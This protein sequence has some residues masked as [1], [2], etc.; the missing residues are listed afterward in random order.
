MAADPMYRKI[1]EDLQ[2]KIETGA[3][4]HGEQL[5]TEMEL[6]DQYDASRNTVR[7]AVKLLITRRLIETRPGQGTFV[8]EKIDPFVT[9]LTDDPESGLGG[10]EGIVYI[11]AVAASGR[12]ADASEPQVEIQRARDE[13]AESL[14]IAVGAQVVCRHQRRRIDDVPWSL[15][16]SFYPMAL[17]QR[18]ATRLLEAT[19]ITEGTVIYLRETLGIKQV[20]YRDSIAVRAPDQNETTFFKLPA[21][22]RV[23]VFSIFRVAFD[24]NFDRFRVTITTYPAD[25]NRFVIKVGTV[26]DDA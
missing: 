1:A 10:G 13:V 3:L 15:Q 4:A 8:V 5:P 20:G 17:V 11:S 14:H 18:G 16:S 26:P 19:D 7:D 21:D 12:K 9:T 6:R 24:K 2:R 22:G 25:R 23:P